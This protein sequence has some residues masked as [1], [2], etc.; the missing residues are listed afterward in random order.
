MKAREWWIDKK[1]GHAYG[2]H[3]DFE[4]L[5]FFHVR[6][7]LPDTV[8]ITREELRAICSRIRIPYENIYEDDLEEAL[9]ASTAKSPGGES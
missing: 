1:N 2:K 8:T 3:H 6:E 7:V 4:P 5:G 9:F